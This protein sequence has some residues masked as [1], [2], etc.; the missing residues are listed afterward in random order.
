VSDRRALAQKV[1][2]F[3]SRNDIDGMLGLMAPDACMEWP[4]VPSGERIQLRGRAQIEDFLRKADE[5]PVRWD[6]FRDVV[7]YETT[8]PEVVIFEYEADGHLSTTGGPFHQSVIVVLRIRDG[9]IVLYRDYINP[10][11]L[12]KAG[13]VPP[14]P[15][16]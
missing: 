2:E 11:M 13:V 6:E 9:R 3:G 4:Y 10:M 1:L 14:E 15:S 12:I 7:I 8:D 16:R 5:S